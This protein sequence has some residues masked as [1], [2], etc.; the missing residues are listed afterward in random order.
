MHTDIIPAPISI[1]QFLAIELY[2]SE[3]K[4]NTPTD[5]NV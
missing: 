2:V 4:V 5:S 3:D 1:P